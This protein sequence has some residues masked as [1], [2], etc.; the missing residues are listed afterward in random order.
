MHR[1]TV[2]LSHQVELPGFDAD[3][4]T[5]YCSNLGEAH[6]LQA[7]AAALRLVAVDGMVL[8]HEWRVPDGHQV[9]GRVS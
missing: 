1:P 5:V 2:S 3:A 4:A 7:T 6:V 9:R 8:R